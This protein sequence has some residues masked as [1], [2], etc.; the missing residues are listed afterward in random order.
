MH[1]LNS[2]PKYSIMR[3][4]SLTSLIAVLVL[5]VGCDFGDVNEDPNNPAQPRTDLLLSEAQKDVGSRVGAVTGTLYSQYFAETQY[6]EASRYSTTN[7]NWSGWYAGPLNDLQTIIDLNSN[8]QTQDASYVLAGGS[9]VNQLWVAKTLK[10]YFFQ[11]IT[12]RWGAVPYHQ[13]LQG[14]EELTPSYNSQEEIYGHMLATLDTAA[15]RLTTNE[16]GPTG[17]YI[18]EGNV[19]QWKRF[20]NTLRMR[21]ALRVADVA[22]NMAQNHFMDAYNN[23]GGPLQSAAMY[24]F[25]ADPNSENPWYSRFE[26]RRDYAI[27]NTM[28]DTMKALNDYRLLAFAN[29]ASAYDNEN[30]TLEFSDINPMPYGVSSDSAGSLN[31]AQVSLIGDA[32]RGQG[33]DLP[34]ISMAELHFLLAEAAAR[35][36]GVNGTAQAHYQAGIEA[37]WNQWNIM[38]YTIVS[39]SDLNAYMNQPEVQ[40]NANE[41]RA[42][43]GYQKW[44]ALFPVGYEA[45]TEWRRLG[46]PSLEPAPAAANPSGTIPARMGYPTSEQDL[47]SQSYN[48]AVPQILGGPDALNTHVWW[49][50]TR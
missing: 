6:T 4:L 3:K 44:L 14:E 5:F 39:S 20:A 27:S 33:T 23:N 13:A 7:F 2:S 19:M 1:L 31:Q 11:M 22:P 48:E 10:T 30:D 25:L 16:A 47:N 36:W 40:W 46:H 8:P 49:D 18:F 35:G 42:K 9:N 15:S 34:I 37:S 21:L 32:M 29:P 28:S 17:D 24:P 43:I 50:D 38:D 41:W 26:T 45:W 12:D